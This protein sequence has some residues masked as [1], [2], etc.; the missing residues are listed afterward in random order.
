MTFTISL[1]DS[2][3][4]S[5]YT[6]VKLRFANTSENTTKKQFYKKQKENRN[7]PRITKK[8]RFVS[9]SNLRSTAT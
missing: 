7:K 5:F 4:A 1:C 3:F 2:E 8:F 6:E 9:D